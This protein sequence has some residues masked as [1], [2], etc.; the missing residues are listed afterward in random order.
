[1]LLI[2]EPA[3]NDFEELVWPAL[4]QRIPMLLKSLKLTGGWAGLL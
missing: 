2:L 3:W 4:A 1:M